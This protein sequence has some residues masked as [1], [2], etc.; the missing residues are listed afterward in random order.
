MPSWLI[1]GTEYQPLWQL[2]VYCTVGINHFGHVYLN[3]LLLP[4]LSQ[5]GRIVV[6]ASGVHDPASPGGAQGQTATL[7]QLQGLK[8]YGRDCAMLDGGPFNA[9]K[10]YKD[11]KVCASLSDCYTSGQISESLRISH[12]SL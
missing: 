5:N 11:S 8:R 7:G 10:A 12:S 2:L 1:L 3:Q 6:T 9:D 4:M